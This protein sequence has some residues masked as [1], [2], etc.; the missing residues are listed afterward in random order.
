MLR[1]IFLTCFYSRC[2]K[3]TSLLRKNGFNNVY[4]LRGGILKYFE[5]VDTSESLFEGECFVFD[6]RITVD[7][8]LE[9][10]TYSKCHACRKPICREQMESPL[11]KVGVSCPLCHGHT[12]HQTKRFR[13]RQRQME[14]AAARGT[15]HLG[16]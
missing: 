3:S 5:E 1:G 15:M 10:G 9:K 4:H 2:E 8:N 6:N 16:S 7:Q 14:L 13:E 12:E 11:Y